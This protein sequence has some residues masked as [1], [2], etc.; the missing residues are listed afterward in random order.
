MPDR[1]ALLA[2]VRG[3][4]TR[5]MEKYRFL[6]LLTEDG[7]ELIGPYCQ[8]EPITWV[9]ILDDDNP[10]VGSVIGNAKPIIVNYPGHVAIV[11][12]ALYAEREGGPVLLRREIARKETGGYGEC[13]FPARSSDLCFQ[14]A[15]PAEAEP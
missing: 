3:L 4:A 6:N 11:A 9:R 10:E 1:L 7:R 2:H 12:L 14:V 13:Y 15:I 5:C 8:R